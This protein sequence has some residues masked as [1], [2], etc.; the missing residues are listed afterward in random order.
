VLLFLIDVLLA[1][2]MEQEG[3]MIFFEPSCV[4]MGDFDFVIPQLLCSVP[5]YSNSIFGCSL[6]TVVIL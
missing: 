4:T 3:T 2:N 5:S 6:W 1:K